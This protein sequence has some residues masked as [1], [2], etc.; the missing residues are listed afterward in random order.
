[1]AQKCI[2]SQAFLR[3]LGESAC[4]ACIPKFLGFFRNSRTWYTEAAH[5]PTLRTC[6]VARCSS[7]CPFVRVEIAKHILKLL[8]PSDSQTI[9]VFPYRTYGNIP[10]RTSL[11]GASNTGGMKKSRFSTNIS[12]YRGK[13]TR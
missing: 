9:L 2:V 3:F 10:T 5:R 4:H 13:D 8:S 1:M 7:V 12:F 6:V 11:T